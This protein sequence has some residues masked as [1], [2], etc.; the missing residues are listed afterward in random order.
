MTNEPLPVCRYCGEGRHPV[1][2]CPRVAAV[3]YEWTWQDGK[4]LPRITRLEFHRP[5]HRIEGPQ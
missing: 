3:E 1:E 4:E 5:F 2:Q